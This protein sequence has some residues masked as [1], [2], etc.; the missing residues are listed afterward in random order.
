MRQTST[1]G[2]SRNGSSQRT[3][4]SPPGRA[5]DFSLP[6]LC[7]ILCN[8][9]QAVHSFYSQITI[10]L[11]KLSMRLGVTTVHTI[12]ILAFAQHWGQSS[13]APPDGALLKVR[14]MSVT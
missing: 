6:V 12:L 11:H 10:K 9:A 7:S 5:A 4:S 13:D 2:R 1:R 14:C 3:G 8:I